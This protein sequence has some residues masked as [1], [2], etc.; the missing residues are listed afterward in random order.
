MQKR[1]LFRLLIL[2]RYSI[3]KSQDQAGQTRS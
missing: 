1:S 2:A 3:L